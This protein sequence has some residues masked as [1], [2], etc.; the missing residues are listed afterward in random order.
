[1]E[2]NDFGEELKKV[3]IPALEE[4]NIELVEL[5]FV[6]RHGSVSLRLL[7]D[8]RE[9]GICIGDCARIN[10]KLGN[11]LDT[12]NLIEERYVLEVSSPGLD[13]PLKTK[14]D[15]L[16]CL[17][18]EVKIFLKEPINGKI[19]FQGAVTGA[20]EDCVVIDSAGQV[21]RIALTNITKGKQVLK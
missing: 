18:K 9:G 6:R 19:E 3:I 16:R 13:R 11:I 5:N 10:S 21:L 8:I 1:M 20:Q 2:L 4:E 15:F 17:N 12:H 7:I 14:N